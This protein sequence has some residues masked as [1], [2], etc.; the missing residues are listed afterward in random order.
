MS[1][2][3]GW[4]AVC[5]SCLFTPPLIGLVYLS[6]NKCRLPAGEGAGGAHGG[7]V[8]GQAVRQTSV[9]VYKHMG[10]TTSKYICTHRV[11]VVSSPM[12]RAI[13]TIEPA[14]TRLKLPRDRWLCYG[15]YYEVRTY[16]TDACV[17]DRRHIGSFI[18]S[19]LPYLLLLITSHIYTYIHIGGGLLP[20][21]SSLPR[22]LKTGAG[23]GAPGMGECRERRREEGG[24]MG[25][26]IHI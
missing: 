10:P 2:L 11:L 12:Q 20:A 6:T 4:L 8:E 9:F 1:I 22:P 7:A 26:G 23:G 3:G 17:I 24:G 16:D 5:D 18:S 25:Q 21:G 14:V 19:L 15:Q 13:K